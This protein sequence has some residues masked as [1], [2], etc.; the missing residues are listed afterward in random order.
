MMINYGS[1]GCS[2]EET[3]IFHRCRTDH[4]HAQ[5]RTLL[6][7]GVLDTCLLILHDYST[8]KQPPEEIDRNTE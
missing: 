8:C 1:I 3:S 4:V 7:E 6:R 5:Q 2:L